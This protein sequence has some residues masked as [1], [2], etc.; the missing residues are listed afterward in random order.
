VNEASVEATGVARE[1]LIGTDFSSYFTEQDKAREG[2]QRV[3]P[4]GFVR[5]YSLMLDGA[6]VFQ[7]RATG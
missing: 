4:E 6:A 3:F 5:D 7:L 2:Y 1:R